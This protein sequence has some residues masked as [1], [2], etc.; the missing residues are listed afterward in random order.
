MKRLA[1]LDRLNPLRHLRQH[2][3]RMDGDAVNPLFLILATHKLGKS[4]EGKLRGLISRGS[5]EGEMGSDRGH[6]ND[7][8]LPL[9]VLGSLDK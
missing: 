4:Q 6:V 2:S 7:I 1:R 8:N 3:S 5:G 9:L